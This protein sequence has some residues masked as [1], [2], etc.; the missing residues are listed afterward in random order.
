MNALKNLFET[1][2]FKKAPA[3]PVKVRDFIV[4]VAPWVTI[5]SIIAALPAVTI[6]F[7]LNAFLPGMFYYQMAG[8]NNFNLVL[9]LELGAL[10]IN[11]LALPGLFH[12]KIAGWDWAYYAV[13][14]QTLAS[15]LSANIVGGIV[16]LAIALYLLFQI[17]S[18][19]K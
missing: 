7:G 14:I 16:G 9:I 18:Y 6:L 19:Y 3:L 15:L 2:L 12:K 13:L 1:Y 8:A 10:V 17:K 11:A 4:L 5:L